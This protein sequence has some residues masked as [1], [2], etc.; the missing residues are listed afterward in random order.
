MNY[1]AG[2]L[3]SLLKFL[4]WPLHFTRLSWA[5]AI[6][7]ESSERTSGIEQQKNWDQMLDSPCW[8]STFINS[9]MMLW[10]S[11][12]NNARMTGVTLEF[13]SCC[14][15]VYHRK[16][17]NPKTATARRIYNKWP[18]SPDSRR[19]VIQPNTCVELESACQGIEHSTLITGHRLQSLND[20]ILAYRKHCFCLVVVSQAW[21]FSAH[22]YNLIQFIGRSLIV[23][24]P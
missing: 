9:F 8:S 24:R 12:M 15:R 20:H 7:D 1:V 19:D 4:T 21:K 16:A 6:R 18:G 10:W 17:K 22:V 3:I 11:S 14:M 2:K 23:Q 13:Y 5:S